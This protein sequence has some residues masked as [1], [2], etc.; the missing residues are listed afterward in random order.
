M[1]PYTKKIEYFVEKL[2]NSN[3]YSRVSVIFDSCEKAETQKQMF[4]SEYPKERFRI[5]ER[6]TEIKESTFF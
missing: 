3:F 5:V 4:E 2:Y 6:V 1:K